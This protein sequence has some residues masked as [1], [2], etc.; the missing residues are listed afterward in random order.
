M[1]DELEQRHTPALQYIPLRQTLPHA[2]QFDELDDRLTQTP[3]QSVPDA[4]AHVP[5]M[6]R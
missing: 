5:P 1:L 2:P 4:H 3:P 6:Q